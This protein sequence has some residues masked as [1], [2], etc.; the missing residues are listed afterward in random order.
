MPDPPAD[1]DSVTLEASSRYLGDKLLLYSVI[2]YAEFQKPFR[3]SDDVSYRNGIPDPSG[4]N[5]MRECKVDTGH[6]AYVAEIPFSISDSLMARA[7]GPG[8]S[9]SGKIAFSYRITCGTDQEE[10]EIHMFQ[11]VHYETKPLGN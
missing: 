11:S 4:P 7:I 2:Y 1:G 5:G 3:F 8:E 9:I 6:M 10:G